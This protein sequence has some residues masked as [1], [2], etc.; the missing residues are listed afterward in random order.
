MSVVRQSLESKRAA[1]TTELGSAGSG[2]ARGVTWE[3][4]EDEMGDEGRGLERLAR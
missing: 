4:R 3:W 2:G 1:P